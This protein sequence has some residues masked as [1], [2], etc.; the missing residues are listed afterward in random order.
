MALLLSSGVPATAQSRSDCPT[1]ADAQNGIRLTRASPLFDMTLQRRGSF[2]T[3]DRTMVR[4]GKRR[5][6]KTTYLHGLIPTERREGRQVITQK[7]GNS[8]TSFV[9]NGRVRKWSSPIEI[10]VGNQAFGT[11]TVK[12]RPAGKARW[13][14][15]GCSYDVTRVIVSTEISGRPTS[16]FEYYYAPALGI[17][18]GGYSL[19]RD[20]RMRTSN[21]LP[22]RIARR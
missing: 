21:I 4:D 5:R 2:V 8:Q 3:E 14:G 19:G 17:S 11:G 6:V 1:A 12:L 20:G 18:L 10:T 13:T 15:N 22:E 9:R 7:L 16:H